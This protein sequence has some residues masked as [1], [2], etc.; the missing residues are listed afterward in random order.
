[1]EDTLSSVN[2]FKEAIADDAAIACTLCGAVDYRNERV[3]DEVAVQGYHAWLGHPRAHGDLPLQSPST[4]AQDIKG[5]ANYQIA[6]DR[7]CRNRSLFV[8]ANGVPGVGPIVMQAGD[9]VAV[10]YGCR[11]PVILRS[12]PTG[13]EYTVLGI[14]YVHGIM[15]GEVV[16]RAR[17]SGREDDTFYLQ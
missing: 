5:S 6:F 10:L 3:S 12:L 14:A 4:L 2:S 17:E 15:D 11:W 8:T 9:I 13:G 7:A 16:S 1:M